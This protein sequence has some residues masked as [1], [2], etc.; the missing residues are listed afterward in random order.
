MTDELLPTPNAMDAVQNGMGMT[1]EARLRQCRSRGHTHPIEECTTTGS[2]AKDLQHLPTPTA[3]DS[4][5]SGNRNLEGS[6][7]HLGTSLT[8]AVR[9]DR[10]SSASSPG[11]EDSTSPSSTSATSASPRSSGTS[12]PPLF[13]NDTGPTSNDGETSTSS[14]LLPTPHAQ[15]PGWTPDGRQDPA[16]RPYQDGQHR[17]WGTPQVVAHLASTSSAEGSPASPPAPPVGGKAPQ[18]IAGSGPSSPVWLASYDPDTSSWRTSQVSL[19]S[20]EDERFPR[21]WERW[22]TSGMTR[23]GEAFELPT[24][25]PPTDAS[26][27]SSL[28]TPDS[29]HGRKETRT[30]PL[31]PGL[32]DTLLHTPTTGDSQ[33]NY[34]HRA[35]PGYTRAKPVPNLH[36]QIDELMPTPTAD[37]GAGHSSPGN[38]SSLPNTVGDLLPTPKANEANGSKPHG[39]GGLGLREAVTQQKNLLPTPEASDATGGRRSKE[40]GGKRPS[41]AKRAIT[42]GTAVDHQRSDGEPTDQPSPGGSE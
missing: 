5:S 36:A 21:S 37:H 19:L 34:D 3:G 17:S 9:D 29:T 2:L 6:K 23:H 8:D 39:D 4:R 15:E 41:G 1:P 25:A 7:A 24:L 28:P 33:P 10:P 26:V 32:V 27:S 42:L 38:F 31:L 20:T 14:V 22:P 18:T 16:H 12:T 30:A 11:S 35:S 13:S 40:K